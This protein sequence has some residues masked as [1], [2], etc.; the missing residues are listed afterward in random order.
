M[1]K[2]TL[3]NETMKRKKS[4]GLLITGAVLLIAGIIFA[5]YAYNTSYQA[6]LT[7]TDDKLQLQ[8]PY[9][10]ALTLIFLAVTATA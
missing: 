5:V 8:R 10:Y 9:S 3:E 2:N 1:K 6:S 4:C 7:A